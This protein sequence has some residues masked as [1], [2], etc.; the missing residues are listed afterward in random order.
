MDTWLSH[1][2]PRFV[3]GRGVIAERRVPAP[4]IIEHLDV[5]KDILCCVFTGRVVPMVHELAL[6]CPE[7]TF[8][9]GVVPAI[10]CAAHAGGDAVGRE[11]VLV[12]RGGILTA[13]IRVVQEP[14]RG[15]PVR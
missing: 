5:L 11:Y 3:L 1:R 4:P 10:A 14:G 7:E 15:C 13:A 6:E 12:P 2:C 9:A 8:D